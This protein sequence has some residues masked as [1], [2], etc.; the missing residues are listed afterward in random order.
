MIYRRYNLT[1]WLIDFVYV[2][3]IFKNNNIMVHVGQNFFN[4]IFT[5]LAWFTIS[6]IYSAGIVGQLYV[7]LSFI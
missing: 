6:Q 5:T 1:N 2:Q 3:G 7:D 4:F